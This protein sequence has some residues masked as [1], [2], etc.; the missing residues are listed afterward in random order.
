MHYY[1]L[2]Y[3]AVYEVVRISSI[4][5]RCNIKVMNTPIIIIQ[6]YNEYYSEMGHSVY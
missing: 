2:S 4:F 5:V 3:H 6:G 1:G